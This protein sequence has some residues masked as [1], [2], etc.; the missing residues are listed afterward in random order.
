MPEDL[1]SRMDSV[2]EEIQRLTAQAEE[3]QRVAQQQQAQLEELDLLVRQRDEQLAERQARVEELEEILRQRDQE[4]ETLRGQLAEGAEALPRWEQ[5][6]AVLRQQLAE[7]EAVEAV[8]REELAR[9]TGSALPA[10]GPAPHWTAALDALT[11]QARAQSETLTALRIWLQ[12]EMGQLHGRLGRLEAGLAALPPP[13]PAK[14]AVAVTAPPMVVPSTEMAEAPAV[15]AVAAAPPT[16]AP[17]TVLPETPAVEA[18]A[19]A[20]PTFAPPIAPEEPLQALLYEVLDNL[21]AAT[22]IGLAS[23]DGLAVEMM[24]RQEQRFALPLEIEL[25]DLTREALH[26]ADALGI[27]PL[28]TIAFQVHAEH[29]LISPIGEDHFVFLLTPL[30]GGEQFRRAQAI[31]LQTAIRLNEIA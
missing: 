12:E 21:P 4:I 22:C 9:L 25:A 2:L 19:A 20:P 5:E 15:E 16:F 17:P 7:K 14:E 28:L 23:L 11:E 6:L 27:G 10:A 30:E 8:L 26:T 24:A 29:C 1:R 31:L 18:V 13:A 3:W